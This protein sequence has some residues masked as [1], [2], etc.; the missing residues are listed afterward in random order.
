[1]PITASTSATPA[2]RKQDRHRASLRHLDFSDGRQRSHSRPAWT[3]TRIS[4]CR[5]GAA[6]RAGSPSVRI[7]RSNGRLKSA[8]RLRGR[9]INHRLRGGDNAHLFH[10]A[11]DTDNGDPLRL[12]TRAH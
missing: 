4:A 2:S 12:Q 11:D 6:S 5:I 3:A 7:A 10:V 9:Q 1:M 8:L